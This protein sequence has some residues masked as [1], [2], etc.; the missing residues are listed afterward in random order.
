MTLNM[1]PYFYSQFLRAYVVPTSFGVLLGQFPGISPIWKPQGWQRMRAVG[2]SV[3]Q[4]Q[5]TQSVGYFRLPDW[6]ENTALVCAI[7]PH[8]S[9]CTWV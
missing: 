5:V 7:K 6:H 9:V 2:L 4:Q 1:P 3:C 8:T